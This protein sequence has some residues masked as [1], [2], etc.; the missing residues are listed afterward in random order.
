MAKQYFGAESKV[1]TTTKK[2]KYTRRA[3]TTAK[4]TAKRTAKTQEFVNIRVPANLAFQ[5]G[6][7]IGQ[8][9]N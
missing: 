4:R 3:A 8:L 2:R 6:V 9:S 5:L 7:H 1:N